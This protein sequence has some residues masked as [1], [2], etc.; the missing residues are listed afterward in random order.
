MIG[1]CTSVSAM[2]TGRSRVINR[3]PRRQQAAGEDHVVDQVAEGVVVVHFLVLFMHIT[4]RP[5]FY[6]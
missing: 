2:T 3:H 4:Y 1:A 6:Q 5:D